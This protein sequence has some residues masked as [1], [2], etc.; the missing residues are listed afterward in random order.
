M[1]IL[2]KRVRTKMSVTIVYFES[3]VGEEPKQFVSFDDDE[4]AVE[5][6]CAELEI[7]C[8]EFE[9]DKYEYCVGDWVISTI[10]VDEDCFI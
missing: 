1:I 9:E 8:P 6:A 3:T 4:I 10:Y 5:R 7:D 2:T